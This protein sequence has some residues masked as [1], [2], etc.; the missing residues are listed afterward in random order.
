MRMTQ[1][2][3]AL[4]TGASGGIGKEIARILAREGFSVVLVA[5]RGQELEK[6]ASELREQHGVKAWAVPADLTRREACDELFAWA[7]RESIEVDVLVNNAGFGTNGRFSDIDLTRELD[8]IQLNVAAPVH[9]T[10]L[11]LKPMLA[12]NRGRILNVGSTAG[13]QPGPFMAVYY[14]TKAFV[15]SFTEALSAELDATSVTATVLCPGP[16]K[17]GFVAAAKM[18]R[19]NLFKAPQVADASSVAEAG[20]RAMLEGKAMVVPGLMNKASVQSTRIAP[21]AVVRAIVKRLNRQH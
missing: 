7:G 8:E 15:N 14:S 6:L 9:L 2:G 3:T 16:T 19:V 4:V 20:V 10:K 18:E 5:R 12:R 17:S 11:F 13:F 1:A 21:R